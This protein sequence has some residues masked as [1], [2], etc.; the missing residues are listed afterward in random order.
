MGRGALRRAS[1]VQQAEA[2]AMLDAMQLASTNGWPHVV[3]E[4]DNLAICSFLHQQTTLCHWQSLPLLRK[5]VDICNINPVW[6]CSFVYRAC[7]KVADAIAKAARK[8]NLCGE[9]WLLPP[10][11][12]IPYISHD[13]RNISV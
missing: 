12:L 7:N 10:A 8:Y 2:W 5:C 4:T 11:M 9:W 3:Y 6:S 1:N 13:V